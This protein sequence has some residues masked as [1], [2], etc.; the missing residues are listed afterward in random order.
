M[1]TAERPQISERARQI[2]DQETR[3]LAETLE[4][5]RRG[6]DSPAAVLAAQCALTNRRS[7]YFGITGEHFPIQDYEGILVI[8]TLDEQLL[9]T[10]RDLLHGWVRKH[11]RNPDLA[12][13]KLV[14]DR[15]RAKGRELSDRPVGFEVLYILREAFAAFE[16]LLEDETSKG[17]PELEHAFVHHLLGVVDRYVQSREKP[18]VRHFSDVAREYSVV[19][20]LKCSCGDEKFEVKMQALC[21]SPEGRPYDRM[22]LQ[23]KSCGTQRSI[24]FDLPHFKDM[25][26]IS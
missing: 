21:Q 16:G 10:V 2:I 14:G 15:L 12:V 20:R 5:V 24:S 22:D 1:T 3:R 9:K 23:C 17:Q 13:L 26:Q 6:L 18:V 11:K 7:A 4:E 25:Y 19:S 8:D